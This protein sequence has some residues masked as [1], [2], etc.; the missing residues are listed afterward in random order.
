MENIKQEKAIMKPI[1]DPEQIKKAKE[2]AIYARNIAKNFFHSK[3]NDKKT[4]IFIAG[5][6]SLIAIYLGISLYIKISALNKDPYSLE[7]INQYDITNLKTNTLTR[8]SIASATT[9]YDLIQNNEDIQDETQRYNKYKENLLYPY[10][11]FLQYLLL[12][13]LNIR[14]EP[15]TDILK[16]DILGRSFLEENPYNDINLLQRRTDFFSSTD[17]N[18]INQIK[19]IKINDI[20][21]YENGIFGI[22]IDFSFVSPSKNAL[23]FL[24]DKITTTSDEENISLLGE[25]FYYL[26][27]Q[28]KIDRKDFLDEQIKN[29]LFSGEN[30]INKTLGY[31]FYNRIINDEDSDLVDDTTINRT[32]F[33][34]MGCSPETESQCFYRFR[35]KYRNIA[36]LAYTVGMKDNT[37]KT[38]DLKDF[39]KNM[40]PI[41]AV[42]EFMYTKVQESSIIKQNTSKFEGKIS[43]EI[44]G[45]SISPEERDEI[46]VDL[47]KKCFADNKILS[48]EEVLN[49]INET[50]RKK[51]DLIEE[52]QSKANSIRDL[53]TIIENIG[54]NYEGLSNY[55]KT[56]KLFEMYRMLNENGLCKTI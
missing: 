14:K 48:P 20:Q 36:G 52:N 55:R 24:T 44:Y 4:I 50:I 53:K 35:E 30:N 5:V 2:M 37:N 6:L 38:E 10:T 43:L 33:T 19:D 23:L 18:E 29:G 45:Q 32:I 1:I 15:Y 11:Y 21:E 40:P 26:R 42:Q 49:T 8:N 34:M 3:K 47:G 9:I 56:I 41:I 13:K 12:P 54:T 31:H 28:I 27:Q 16:T 46:A 39:L 7:K 25:F 17:Q 22:K 51:S